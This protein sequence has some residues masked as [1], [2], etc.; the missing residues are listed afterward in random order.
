LWYYCSLGGMMITG[1]VVS[2][3]CLV[4]RAC[5]I[6]QVFAKDVVGYLVDRRIVK[7]V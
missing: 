6:A 3:Q 2:W 7:K 1:A 5:Y 4:F